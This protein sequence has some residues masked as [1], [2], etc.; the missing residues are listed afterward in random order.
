MTLAPSIREKEL[1]HATIVLSERCVRNGRQRR[2]GGDAEAFHNVWLHKSNRHQNKSRFLPLDPNKA[3]SCTFFRRQT[4]SFKCHY[5]LNQAEQSSKPPHGIRQQLRWGGGYAAKK[6][7]VRVKCTRAVVSSSSDDLSLCKW[8]LGCSGDGSS[9]GDGFC[10][11]QDQQFERSE[12]DP[13]LMERHPG[14][15]YFQTMLLLIY[16][17]FLYRKLKENIRLAFCGKT[18]IFFLWNCVPAS[19]PSDDI[20][21]P[22]SFEM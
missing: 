16:L 9:P 5:G 19:G 13:K 18:D 12:E 3:T 11:S 10:L 20:F 14:Q 17:I 21:N 15:Q 6:G 4:G 8:K 7:C 2:E 1:S 22:A